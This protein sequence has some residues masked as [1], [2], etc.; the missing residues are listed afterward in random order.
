MKPTR[1]RFISIS[2][3]VAATAML[4]VNGVQAVTQAPKLYKWQGVAMGAAA[5]ISL[6]AT[7]ETQA[8]N[9]FQKC[10]NEI[11]RLEN[12]FSLFKPQSDIS[13]LNATGQILN[14]NF[15]LVE[16]LSRCKTYS[17]LT[18][19][20]FDVTIQPLWK[21]Y[22]NHFAKSNAEISAIELNNVLKLV[23]SN[24]IQ[25]SSDKISFTKPN[26]AISLNGVAQ[27]Y[28]TD[29][30]TAIL[31]QA[32]FENMLVHM[33]ETFA[34]GSHA[35]G[36]QWSAGITSPQNQAEI[37]QRVPLKN[38]AIATSGGYG[39]KFSNHGHHHL[40]NPKTGLSANIYASVSVV[41]DDSLT[42]DMLSTAFYIMPM[43]DIDAI[44][45]AFPQLQKAIFIDFN[46]EITEKQ[47]INAVKYS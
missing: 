16:L 11:S 22:K 15:E 43:H 42:A 47:A 4:Y 19:G 26:M 38:Q 33:G 9:L 12:I 5:Q 3:S 28:L 41:A 34:L 14:P 21:F 24:A 36:H 8:E 32:G 10:E 39:N 35:D 2:A 44:S 7:S 20:A 31:Q 29:K 1:R 40:L 6:Y 45:G 27:G 30:I 25:L 23:G 13:K 46:G 37:A 18:D 17:Q